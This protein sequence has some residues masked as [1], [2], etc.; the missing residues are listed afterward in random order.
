VSVWQKVPKAM[1][2]QLT[3]VKDEMKAKLQEAA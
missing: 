2:K 3:P 1:Q